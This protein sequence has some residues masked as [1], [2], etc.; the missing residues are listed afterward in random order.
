MGDRPP[1]VG[2]WKPGDDRVATWAHHQFA[3]RALHDVLRMADAEGIE[4]LPVKGIVLAHRLYSGVEE[5]PL[6]DVDLRIRPED[7]GAFADGARHRGWVVRRPSRQLGA[8]EFRLHRTLV[9][10]ETTIGPPGLCSIGVAEM[11]DRSTLGVG[12]LGFEHR[13]PELHDHALLL[14]VNVFKDKLVNAPPWAREDLVR[15]SLED[16]FSPEVLR[17]RAADA[18]LSTLVA[19]VARWLGEDERAAQWREVRDRLGASRPLYAAAY[20]TLVHRAPRGL[21]L[22]VLAR[23]ASDEPAARIRALALAV[24]GTAR[25]GFD[26]ILSSNEPRSPGNTL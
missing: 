26:S 7:M 25:A 17:S 12:Q 23:V 6:A 20:M 4:V 18:G 22:A 9:E 3:T 21:L 5:R 24:A 10:V 13:E 2:E 16:G 15:I 19:I 11:L 1:Q 8:L 14:C